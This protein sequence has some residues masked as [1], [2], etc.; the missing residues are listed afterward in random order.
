MLCSYMERKTHV[1]HGLG[2]TEVQGGIV[3]SSQKRDGLLDP[4]AQRRRLPAQL[5]LRLVAPLKRKQIDVTCT[6]Y[7]L[8]TRGK[9]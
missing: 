1:L 6:I 2:G 8:R 4:L 5:A 3:F 9:P 7:L